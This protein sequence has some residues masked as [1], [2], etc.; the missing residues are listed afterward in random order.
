MRKH[1]AGDA[2]RFDPA[3]LEGFFQKFLFGSAG[4]DIAQAFLI[5]KAAPFGIFEG[6]PADAFDDRAGIFDTIHRAA[7]QA[8]NETVDQGPD[9]DE[10]QSDDG[11]DYEN[12][13][14]GG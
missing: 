9:E 5:L 10:R 3:F 4:R 13:L 11:K 6:F 7:D 1:L 12:K 2:G 8:D 14:V